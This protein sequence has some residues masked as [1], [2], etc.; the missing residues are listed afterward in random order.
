MPRKPTPALVLLEWIDA[1]LHSDVDA[2]GKAE[3]AVCQTVGWIIHEDAEKLEI[4]GEYYT[5]ADDP[6]GERTW[7]SVTVL[8]GGW[9]R[10]RRKL[11]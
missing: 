10:K 8:P 1:R 9:V 7:R 5:D 4:A 3:L 6:D 11:S 2:P